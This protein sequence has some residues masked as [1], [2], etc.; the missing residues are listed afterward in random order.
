MICFQNDFRSVLTE[1]IGN[2][3]FDLQ[4]GIMATKVT[5]CIHH[6]TEQSKI[7]ETLIFLLTNKILNGSK[8]KAFAGDKRNVTQDF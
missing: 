2:R 4:A 1:S 6:L 5:Y 7:S 8:L 3:V